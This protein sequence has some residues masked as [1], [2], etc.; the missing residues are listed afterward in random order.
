MGLMSSSTVLIRRESARRWAKRVVSGEDSASGM[1]NP[2]TRSD[3]RAR[4]QSPA[5]TFNLFG[6]LTGVNLQHFGRELEMNLHSCAPT[7]IANSSLLIFPLE[8]LGR[9]CRNSTNLGTMKS[10]KCCEQ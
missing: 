10:S 1:N 2:K 5:A 3:P 4:T 9:E 7:G 6:N 8:V